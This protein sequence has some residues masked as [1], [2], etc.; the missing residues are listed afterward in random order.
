MNIGVCVKVVA[1]YELPADKFELENNRI[2][3][4]YK[5]MIGLYDEC[6]I[7]VALK[8]KSQTESKLYVISYARPEHIGA[9]KK[10]LSMGA[11][12]LVVINATSDDPFLTA[13]NLA[14]AIKRFDIDIVLFGRV[15]SDLEREIV[16][17]LTAAIL[18]NVYLPYVTIIDKDD[19]KDTF[20]CNQLLEDKILSLK[21]RGKFVASVTDAPINLP[22]IPNLKEIMKSKSKP[23]HT[24]NEEK[25]IPFDWGKEIEVFIPHY[26]YVNEILPSEDLSQVAALLLENLKKEH[27]L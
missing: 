17:P 6:A 16:P 5:E 14:N 19:S 26:E 3:N 8:L 9:L 10:G 1:D 18:E 7:E 27:F 2:A 4:K 11:D 21:V 23:I 20:I 24:E 13:Q 22:R 12:A 15:S 25:V